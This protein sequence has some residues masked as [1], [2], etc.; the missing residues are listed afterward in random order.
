[1]SEYL[2]ITAVSKTDAEY[3]PGSVGILSANTMVKIVDM[4]TSKN[5]GPNLDGEVCVKG[6]K[7]FSGYINND[8]ASKEAFDR[9]GWYRTGDIGHYDEKER[10]FITDRVMLMMTI[11][12]GNNIKYNISPV[13]IEMF[14]L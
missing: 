13:E 12:I 6:N 14:L 11:S 1:M 9:D 4:N 5:V 7:M 8:E 10:I 2:G 3:I